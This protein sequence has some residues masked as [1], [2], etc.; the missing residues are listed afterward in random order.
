MWGEGVVGGRGLGG[1]GGG[2]HLDEQFVHPSHLY[3]RQESPP[4]Q[5]VPELKGFRHHNVG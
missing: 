4:P 1:G 2:E 3:S 5:C